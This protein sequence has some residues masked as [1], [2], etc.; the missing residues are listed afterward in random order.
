MG[1]VWTTFENVYKTD[2]FLEN[3]NVLKLIQDRMKKMNNP[4][5][6]KINKQ[7]K[8]LPSKKIPRRHLTSRI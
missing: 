1:T 3:Y 6:P 5:L 4:L 8:Q 2:K 7:W